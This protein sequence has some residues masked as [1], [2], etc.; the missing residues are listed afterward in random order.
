MN[1]QEFGRL[2]QRQGDLARAQST[3]ERAL[4]IFE[5]VLGPEHH[6]MAAGLH[7]LACLRL[8]QGDLAGARPLIERALALTK[9]SL[10]YAPAR[11]KVAV[12]LDLFIAGP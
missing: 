4:A 6:Y 12:G 5:K 7:D 8:D 10:A 9:L 3:Q 2:L 11:L 1:I